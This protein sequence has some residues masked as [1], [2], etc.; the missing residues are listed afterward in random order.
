M[1]KNQFNADTAI[2]QLETAQSLIQRHAE[3][4]QEQSDIEA[5]LAEMGLGL[6]SAPKRGRKTGKRSPGRPKGS[7]AKAN[8]SNRQGGRT[9]S[10]EG[11]SVNDHLMRDILPGS[12]SKEGC[13]RQEAVDALAKVGVKVGGEDP[14]VIV[15][16]GLTSLKKDGLAKIVERGQYI[17]SAKGDKRHAELVEAKK[18]PEKSE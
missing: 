13:T 5:E 15:G 1:A 8:K 4:K 12:D 7:K 6:G 17:R 14:R 2:G 3:L 10:P 11:L 16:Q 9:L 18:N